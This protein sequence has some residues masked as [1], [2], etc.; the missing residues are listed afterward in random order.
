M[1]SDLLNFSSIQLGGSEKY[2]GII[3]KVAA[4]EVWTKF[5]PEF[6]NICGSYDYSVNF[7]NARMMFRKLHEA[8]NEQWK[9]NK[10][11]EA[12][13]FPFRDSFEYQPTKLIIKDLCEVNVNPTID[14]NGNLNKESKTLLPQP[15]T[16]NKIRW[17]NTFLNYEQKSA[18]INILKGEGRPMPYII[19]GPPGTGKTITLIESIIQVY[20][21]FPKSK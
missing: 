17:F 9:T 13:L 20:K 4:D 2:E 10:L 11:G 5:D 15:K 14:C 7:F 6:H 18:V 3:H 19:Y 8:V 21:E 16:I 1:Q 12:F